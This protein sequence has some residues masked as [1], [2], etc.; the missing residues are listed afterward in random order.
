MKSG[1]FAREGRCR[2]RNPTKKTGLVERPLIFVES[3]LVNVERPLIFMERP[4]IFVERL[5]IFMERLLIFVE[6]L[7]VI[8]E[9]PLIFVE[10]L[11]ADEIW[12]LVLSDKPPLLLFCCPEV[13]PHGENR[14]VSNLKPYQPPPARSAIAARTT[15]ERPINKVCIFKLT[16]VPYPASVRAGTEI[17]RPMSS[18]REPRDFI[19]FCLGKKLE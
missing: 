13:C 15:G 9:R 8:V 7:L 6:R 17:A 3:L 14:A 11:P 19:A 5:L 1:I 16:N 10:S 2:V 18:R 4:L 12:R